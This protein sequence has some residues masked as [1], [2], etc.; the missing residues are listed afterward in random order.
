MRSPFPIPHSTFPIPHSPASAP[1]ALH[2]AWHVDPECLHMNVLG[3]VV[4][5]ALAAGWDIRLDCMTAAAGGASR[6]EPE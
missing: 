5:Q 3:A 1:W 2:M 6:S 4:P